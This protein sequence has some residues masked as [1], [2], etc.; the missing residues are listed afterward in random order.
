MQHDETPY[1]QTGP[2]TVTVSVQRTTASIFDFTTSKDDY[3]GGCYKWAYMQ[4]RTQTRGKGADG[5]K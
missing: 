5:N 4:S 3:S 2:P 1:K